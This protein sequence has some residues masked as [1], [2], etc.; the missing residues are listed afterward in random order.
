MD[1]TLTIEAPSFFDETQRQSPDAISSISGAF[2]LQLHDSTLDG[3]ADTL[4]E[5]S[6]AGNKTRVVFVNAHCI[7][8]MCRNPEYDNAV[9]SADYVLPDGSGIAIANVMFSGRSCTNLNGT[10]L[11]PILFEKAAK[12]GLSVYF[13]GGLPGVA[14]HMSQK[15]TQR[16]SGLK[17][18]GFRQGYFHPSQEKRVIQEINDARPDM[19]LV[20]M[21]VP[22]QDVWLARH[23]HQLNAK[24][25]MGVGGLFDFLSERLPRAPKFLRIMGSEWVYRLMQEPKRMWK[26][27]ILGNPEFIG[28]AFIESSKENRVRLLRKVNLTVKRFIDVVGAF[29]GL[30]VL[31]PFFLMTSVAIGLESR[32]PIL[33]R[34][35]RVG[36]NG[37]EFS[38]LKFRSM[39]SEAEVD[40]NRLVLLNKH[41][42]D[43]VTFKMRNDPRITRIGRLIRKYSIDE[44]PQLWNV[45]RG[46]MSLVGPRPALPHEVT[47]Y[48]NFQYKRLA[49]KP[50][51]TCTWQVSGR[52]NIAFE[53]Q[54]EMDIKYINE[55]SILTDLVILLKTPKAVISAV[56]AY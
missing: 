9:R 53:K 21:G 37:R 40:K 29:C 43:G 5:R 45:L 23:A 15:L 14:K 44:L 31:S 8:Q 30:V 36:K 38:L 7:N 52:S 42:G 54:A 32:G 56:G 48:T 6:E 16:F 12:K 47:R 3:V 26:R 20:A 13:F 35:I 25:V 11:A 10:D 18:A 41:G 24:M 46:D 51:L 1:S 27:Y 17:V 19:I 55:Q 22:R 39:L 2:G 33:F 28:R 50:G 34:Q 4:I 49:A